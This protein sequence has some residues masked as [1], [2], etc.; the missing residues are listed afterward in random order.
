MGWSRNLPPDP[1]ARKRLDLSIA[2]SAAPDDDGFGEQALFQLARRRDAVMVRTI[3]RTGSNAEDGM[4]RSS[5][6][7]LTILAAL[8]AI[9]AHRAAGQDRA[10]ADPA[11]KRF[12]DSMHAETMA[13]DLGRMVFRKRW[14]ALLTETLYSIAQRGTWNESSPA[15]DAGRRVIED[16]LRRKSA[17]WLAE[18][19]PEIRL[20]V[21]EQSKQLLT[22]D[23]M[24]AATQ[25]FESP[26]G[27][28]WRDRREGL[29]R[30]RTYGLPFVEEVR[31]LDEIKAANKVLEKAL[32]E[33]P[34]EREGKEVYDF[35]QSSLGDKILKLQ[36]EAFAEI[37]ANIFRSEMDAIVLRDLAELAKTVRERVPAI[38]ADSNKA[39]LGWVV[40]GTDGTFEVTIEHYRT[41]N[42]IGTYRLKY[43]A[44]D[45]H[46]HDIAAAVP[47]IAPG[48]RRFLYRDPNGCLGDRP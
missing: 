42:L 9:S 34:E 16:V 29:V 7:L 45:P 2:A 12:T 46:W 8:C 24:T 31:T 10:T 28:V 19:R 15:W 17:A 3:V 33:L 13:V 27:R 6:R 48:Q 21:Y 32:L 37:A 4:G 20:I 36:N 47:G 18:N 38:P 39:Y 25:F 41:L 5:I 14:Q 1:Q 26:G 30:E 22:A 23:E 44:S 43:S 11:V 35:F 40:M